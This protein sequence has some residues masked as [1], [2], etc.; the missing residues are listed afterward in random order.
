[1]ALSE[2]LTQQK[3]AEILT[4]VYQIGQDSKTINITDFIEEIKQQVLA[5][6]K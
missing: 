5:E 1:M 3:F 4:M 6:G 2:T